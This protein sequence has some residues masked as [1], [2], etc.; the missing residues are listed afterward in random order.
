MLGNEHAFISDILKEHLSTASSP[1][2][3][4][5]PEAEGSQDY[6]RCFK[7]FTEIGCA[8]NWGSKGFLGVSTFAVQNLTA[9]TTFRDSRWCQVLAP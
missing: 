8:E 2:T 5:Q 4:R 9:D 6:C 1:E 7:H 3:P